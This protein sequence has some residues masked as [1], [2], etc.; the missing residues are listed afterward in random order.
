[1]RKQGVWKHYSLVP[2]DGRFHRR[3][4]HCLGDCFDEVRELARD[5]KRYERLKGCCPE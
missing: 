5:R 2:A 3:L 1:V 4:L